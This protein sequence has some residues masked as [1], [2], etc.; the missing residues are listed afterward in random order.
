MS[1]QAYK[2]VHC[3]VSKKRHE[4]FISYSNDGFN[5]SYRCELC[6][7]TVDNDSAMDVH[8]NER[9][10]EN[11]LT[12][13]QKLRKNDVSLK[14]AQLQHRIDKL[15]LRSWQLEVQSHLY[16]LLLNQ[17][18]KRNSETKR[19]MRS[20]EVALLQYERR[21]TIALLE[22]AVWKGVCMVNDDHWTKRKGYLS[23]KVWSTVGWKENKDALQKSNA[24]G[25][26]V[27]AVLPFLP[28]VDRTIPVPSEPRIRSMT[29]ESLEA[30]L[31][32]FEESS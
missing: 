22:L 19:Q 13:V 16:P 25:I 11:R 4:S 10:H 9:E 12:L 20:A 28:S 14:C 3:I 21:E 29:A 6:D 18:T 24:I 27:M 31:S 8:C 2:H 1:F 30:Y 5:C 26:I 23:W 15:S 7:V 32:D 17:T